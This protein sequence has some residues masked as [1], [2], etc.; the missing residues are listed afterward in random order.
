M[1]RNSKEP[2]LQL[3]KTSFLGRITANY[4]RSFVSNLAFLY[5]NGGFKVLY[6]VALKEILKSNY[7]MSPNQLQV[8]EAFILFPWD[9]KILYGIVADT[10]ILPCFSLAPRRGWVLIFSLV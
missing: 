10:I 5:V 1:I 9:F 4:D 8:A 6:S 7:G 2:L 3:E